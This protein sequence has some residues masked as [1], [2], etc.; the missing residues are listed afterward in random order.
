MERPAQP[1]E[2]AGTMTAVSGILALRWDP[3][4]RWDPLKTV[5]SGSGGEPA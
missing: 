4:N 2:L 1:Y 3:L 5:A